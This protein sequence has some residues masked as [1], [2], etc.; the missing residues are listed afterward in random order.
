VLLATVPAFRWLWS[1][2]DVASRHLRRYTRAQFVTLLRGAGLD[3]HYCGYFNSLLF[4]LAVA[5]IVLGRLAR[6]NAVRGLELPPPVVNR[7]LERIFTL[8][9]RL[10]PRM[11]L[12]FGLSIVALAGR[13]S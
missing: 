1:E 2:L 6:R 3:V 7:A 9:S 11:T 4:P 12:P 5:N 8:E 10:V 13:A